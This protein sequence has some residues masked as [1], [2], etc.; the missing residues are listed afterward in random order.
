MHTSIG[1]SEWQQ[2]PCAL[3]RNFTDDSSIQK[4]ETLPFWAYLMAQSEGDDLQREVTYTVTSAIWR[5]RSPEIGASH[6]FLGIPDWWRACHTPERDEWL[7]MAPQELAPTGTFQRLPDGAITCDKGLSHFWKRRVTGE[8]AAQVATDGAF[9]SLPDWRI[10]CDKVLI[11]IRK[12]FPK[13]FPEKN[14]SWKESFFRLQNESVYRIK[15]KK[16]I[17][18]RSFSLDEFTN[19]K[20]NETQDSL[21]FG[22]S[23]IEQ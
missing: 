4:C 7:A 17:Q 8:G 6:G 19:S 10:T 23:K 15:N 18:K 22:V 5:R 2:N 21:L 3:Y 9:Q 11:T 14:F 16:F 12:I 13:K 1:L 20:M